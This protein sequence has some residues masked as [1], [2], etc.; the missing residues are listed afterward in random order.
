MAR[1]FAE[2]DLGDAASEVVFVRCAFLI[3]NLAIVMKKVNSKVPSF[4][5]LID[6]SWDHNMPMVSLID[7]AQVCVS[8]LVGPKRQSS[9]RIHVLDVLGPR[10]YTIQEI[11]Y[12]FQKVVGRELEVNYAHEGNSLAHPGQSIQ[13]NCIGSSFPNP[14]KSQVHTY[15]GQIGITA[16]LRKL[17]EK[18]M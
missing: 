13:E 7:V 2:Q 15:R 1:H 9:Y 3:K 18:E 8:E 6:T 4:Y 5:S 11:F 14:S 10:S 12:E 17:Y 16:T